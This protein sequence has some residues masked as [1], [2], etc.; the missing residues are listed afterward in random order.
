MKRKIRFGLFTI[1]FCLGVFSLLFTDQTNAQRI[2]NEKPEANTSA[3]QYTGSVADKQLVTFGQATTTLGTKHFT[4][5]TWFKR[6]SVG[7]IVSTGS[8]GLQSAVLLITKGRGEGDSG[9]VDMNYFLGISTVVD[10]NIPGDP[11][12][13]WLG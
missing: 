2:G 9:Y 5:E 10:P 7:D 6:T 8:G 11:L 1:I 4:L 12:F 13:V 3:L